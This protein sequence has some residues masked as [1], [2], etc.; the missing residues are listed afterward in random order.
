VI[1]V[2]PYFN[3][4]SLRGGTDINQWLDSLAAN[5]NKTDQ[6]ISADYAIATAHG[7]T[8]VGYESGLDVWPASFGITDSLAEQIRFHPRMQTIYTDML[9]KWKSGGGTLINQY[10]FCDPSWGLL[11]YQDQD[12]S[13]APAY[14]AAMHFIRSNPRWWTETRAAACATG[15][16][17]IKSDRNA[18]SKTTNTVLFRIIIK[19]GKAGIKVT[20]NQP[21]VRMFGLDGKIVPLKIIKSENESLIFPDKRLLGGCYIINVAGYG[22]RLLTMRSA[23][24]R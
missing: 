1:A 10:T 6:K 5:A 17:E 18:V 4:G 9:N 15:V 2:A 23:L 12:T 13:Q 22:S 8:I 21:G 16:Q 7:M 20:G 14:L 11:K 3:G 24:K 19:D